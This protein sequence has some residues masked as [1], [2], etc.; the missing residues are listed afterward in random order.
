MVFQFPPNGKVRVNSASYV[1]ASAHAVKVSIPSKREGTCERSCHDSWVRRLEI[2][3]SIPSKRE[4]TC[5]P[6]VL[7]QEHI[8]CLEV[9]IPSKREG[10]CE[11]QTCS[12][13]CGRISIV[14]IPS[15]REGT[16]ELL[17]LT[18]ITL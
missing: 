17:R 16:C 14:S 5:E 1:C 15:K 12:R 9:S 6:V 4:G 13:T 7:A 11:L 8:A 3:V 18:A 10:T 2:C